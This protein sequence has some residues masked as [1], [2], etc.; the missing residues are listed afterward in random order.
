MKKLIL[1]RF[2]SNHKK[3]LGNLFLNEDIKT[4]LMLK[5][6]ELPWVD[7]KPR[8]SC[9]PKGTYQA[10]VHNS[11]KFGWC[12]WF[13]NVPGRSEILIH[14]GNFTSQILGCILPGVLHDDINNDGIMDVKHSGIAIEALRHYIGD[15]GEIEIEIR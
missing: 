14:Q 13:Q 2:F 1:K 7:N 12:L 5:T 15:M 4:I 10:K 8:I 6:L 11:S 3:T 9:I